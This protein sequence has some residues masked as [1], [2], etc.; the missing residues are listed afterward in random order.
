MLSLLRRRWF[1]LTLLLGL[2]IAW[3]QPAWLHWT[4]WPDPRLVVSSAMFLMAW[5][6]PSRNLVAALRQPGAAL[7]AFTLSYG[8]L[9]PLAWLAGSLGLRPDFSIGLLISASIPCTVA[10][11]VIWT[12]MAGGDDAVALLVALLTT[13]TSWLITTSWLTLTT[14]ISTE[15]A[16]GQMMLDLLLAL[17]LPVIIGQLAQRPPFLARLSQN[18]KPLLG[19]LAQV[20]ILTIILRAASEVSVRLERQ[21]ANTSWL[22]V[23]VGGAV[24]LALHLLVL[25]LGL[26]SSRWLGITRESSIAVAFACSQKSLPV[27][28]LLFERYFQV[29]YPLAVVPLLFY[30]CGQLILDTFVVELVKRPDKAIDLPEEG[31]VA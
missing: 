8:L 25:V 7:W 9:P 6:L 14:G 17:V 2:L 3:Q 26:I 23:L 13:A 5:S 1:L 27:G 15:M 21:G 22:E 12:R 18:Q 31:D 19:V 4:T 30:H 28:L 29:D 11:A 20:L 10:S 16:V 24:A